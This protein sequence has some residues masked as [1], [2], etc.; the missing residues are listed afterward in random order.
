MDLFT[1]GLWGG[2]EANQAI[3][4]SVTVSKCFRF[5]LGFSLDFFF[6]FYLFV[7][8]IVVI[9]IIIIIDS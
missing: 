3:V 9:I 5:L 6:F 1:V 8:K 7:S 2:K 4:E